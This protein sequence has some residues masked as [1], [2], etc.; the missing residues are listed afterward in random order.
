[1]SGTVLGTGV[2]EKHALHSLNPYRL[3]EGKERGIIKRFYEDT[4]LIYL[5]SIYYLGK[6]L[7]LLTASL[8]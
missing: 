7:G 5:R 2:T 3:S 6:T 4:C 8:M 1:M